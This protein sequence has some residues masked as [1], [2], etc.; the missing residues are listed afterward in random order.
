[1]GPQFAKARGARSSDCSS[2][3]SSSSNSS[4]SVSQG[5]SGSSS[6]SSANP[7]L[8]FQCIQIHIF[9]QAGR[10]KEKRGEEK[11]NPDNLA[12]TSQRMLQNSAVLLVLVISASATHEAEQNDSVSPRK[13]RVAAQNS[14]KRQT[15][16]RFLPPKSCP[17]LPLAF[18]TVSVTADLDNKCASCLMAINCQCNPIALGSG[19][20]LFNKLHAT[21]EEAGRSAEGISLHKPSLIA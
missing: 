12:E 8:G 10:G 1:M 5:S 21:N 13:P 4:K 2:I 9:P 6:K 11:E 7:H 20:P 17:H 16:D 18:A 19:A 15:Q 3:S 14:G